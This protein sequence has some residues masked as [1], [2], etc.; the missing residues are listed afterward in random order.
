MK[1]ALYEKK[2]VNEIEQIL[3]NMLYNHDV[4]GTK[5]NLPFP[6]KI[7]FLVKQKDGNGS[8]KI[9]SS[10]PDNQASYLK[11]DFK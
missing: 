1:N 5:F 6:E 2:D 7:P 10:K 9:K 3:E 11:F 4:C 8:M